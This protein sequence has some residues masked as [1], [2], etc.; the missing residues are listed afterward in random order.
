MQAVS[1]AD[2]VADLVVQVQPAAETLEGRTDD[3]SLVTIH[4]TGKGEGRFVGPTTQRYL[5][6][7][8]V[9]AAVDLVLP[10]RTGAQQAD[11]LKFL[12]GDEV[13]AVVVLSVLAQVQHVDLLGDGL[14]ADVILQRDFG[15]TGLTAL[16]R[17]QDYAVS[18]TG[19]VNGRSRSVLQDLNGLNVVGVD[20]VQR[21]G[22]LNGT[23]DAVVEGAADAVVVDHRHAVDNEKRL[24]RQ[25]GTDPADLDGDRPA[26]SAGILRHLDAGGAALNG[27]V[28]PRNGYLAQFLLRNGGEGTRDVGFLGRTV[29]DHDHL[30]KSLYVLAHLNVNNRLVTDRN[31]LVFVAEVGKNEDVPFPGGEGVVAID[32][33]R[34]SAR[35]P[36]HEN[37]GTEQGLARFGVGHLAGDGADDL[38]G[39][40]VRIG[41]NGN[42]RSRAKQQGN[43]QQ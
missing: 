19:T 7:V 17:N 32:V 34:R 28:E 16:G 37:G 8:V 12:D 20:G 43:A 22:S 40:G 38:F 5:G 31:A 30:F 2:L 11:V 13:V 9:G 3:D 39:T 26:G 29:A 24:G 41:V 18:A 15:P 1:N 36:L 21:V 4:A 25:R 6:V 23:L 10:V 33:R 42:Q 27:L 14:G 35:S